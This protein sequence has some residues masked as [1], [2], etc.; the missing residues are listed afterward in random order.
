M[1]LNR[2]ISLEACWL[3][4]VIVASCAPAVLPRNFARSPND[5]LPRRQSTPEVYSD[6][7]VTF[8]TV[9]LPDGTLLRTIRTVPRGLSAGKLAGIFIVGW[10]SCDSMESP[11]DSDGFAAL[12]RRLAQN[13]G[14]V[15]FRV[16]KPGVGDS[17]GNCGTTDF[18][19]ELA[20]YKAAFRL[21]SR[22]PNVDS[23]KLFIVGLSN[24]GG[25]APLVAQ[26]IPLRGIVSISGWGVTW[27][28]HMLENERTRL[29]LSHASPGEISDA[30][31][32]FSVF[33]DE[34]L[35][36]EKTPGDV[37]RA[38]PSFRQI[39]HD[40]ESGQYGRPAKFYQDLQR[41]NLGEAWSRLD[42]PVLVIHGSFDWVMSR[43]DALAI[44][45]AVNA[46]N[47]GAAIFHEVP[48]SHDLRHYDDMDSSFKRKPAN[49]EEAVAVLAISF[50][51]EQS[52][53]PDL[54]P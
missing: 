24:G 34:Y 29:S 6:A 43:R 49:F 23:K 5:P 8:G 45:D 28:E 13:S 35:N 36:Q 39:W 18:E 12:I 37:L 54:L 46:K 52:A 40:E 7:N 4:A 47:P 21:F 44:T 31:R 3:C 25:I 38:H 22:D 17:Q 41:L 1:K 11:S 32:K 19:T 20:G 53:G 51:H 27:Y 16:D 30:M 9:A 50:V 48:T 14:T 10:L 42:A 33:Y 15:T 26:D 2:R